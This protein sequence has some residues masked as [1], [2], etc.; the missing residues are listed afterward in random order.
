MVDTAHTLCLQ[1]ML[2]SRLQLDAGPIVCGM[3]DSSPQHGRAYELAALTV[4]LASDM[5]GVFNGSNDLLEL[6]LLPEAAQCQDENI[7]QNMA[8][9][10][11]TKKLLHVII[12]SPAVIGRGRATVGDKLHA[13]VHMLR[14]LAPR[15][16]MLEQ[17]IKSIVGLC[18][19][20]GT[21]SRI[22]QTTPMPLS[23]L[24]PPDADA[25]LRWGSLCDGFAGEG[26]EAFQWEAED[27][28]F[29]TVPKGHVQA[30]PMC[31]FTGCCELPGPLH[32]IH[33]M[34]KSLRTV[35]T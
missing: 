6:S 8:L 5:E 10:G 13:F 23:R 26:A 12:P 22:C 14:T 9:I 35:L 31:D 15:L 27:A 34:T 3:L 33:N 16:R 17:L 30:E 1:D 11:A 32:A 18:T 7:K 29:D 28:G 2:F 19:D 25:P 20:L 21:E 24:Q 4:V